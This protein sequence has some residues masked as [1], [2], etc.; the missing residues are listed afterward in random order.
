M[1]Q[2][3]SAD[4]VLQ[5]GST[6]G[7]ALFVL[8]LPSSW[9]FNTK[10][11]S[12]Y[13]LLILAHG[14]RGQGLPLSA[15]LDQS[16]HTLKFAYVRQLVQQG[17]VVA[18]TSYRRN[19]WIIADAIEDVDLLRCLVE[20]R[21]GLPQ[22]TLLMGDSM[23]GAI[24]TQIAERKEGESKRY[25]GVVGVG[26]ALYTPDAPLV[27]SVDNPSFTYR[28][29]IP[30]LYL[31][32]QSEIEAPQY[33]VNQCRKKQGED[34]GSG[35][36]GREG[37][38]PAFW[39]VYRDGHCN[40]NTKERYQAVMAVD[41]WI[42]TGTM[43]KLVADGTVQPA[44]GA[45]LVQFTEEHEKGG[46]VASGQILE[47]DVYGNLTTN[48]QASDLKQMG[49]NQF[50]SFLLNVIKLSTLNHSEKPTINE[51][52]EKTENETKNEKE[53]EDEDEEELR[54]KRGSGYNKSVPVI[55]GTDYGDVVKGG[56]VGFISADG[57]L[58]VVKNM[59]NGAKAL[60][61]VT[62]D[63]IVIKPLSG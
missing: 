30:V 9:E 29:Q 2:S 37:V 13:T 38:V 62:G 31:T 1:Q 11:T 3:D 15:D 28:P 47:V 27:R 55:Y 36:G 19:G 54:N 25:H 33:Y 32:N 8:V 12:P 16:H 24:V 46:L 4:V 20:E 53:E 22:H 63:K 7:G 18:S 50:H 17:W 52:N 23:G 6:T 45:S 49:I 51:K 48:F 61:A 41:Q 60:G 59:E 42:R 21:Y 14:Y 10:R 43:E 56:W 40:V 35:E 57:F 44:I 39:T 5:T 58:F 34:P 26:A